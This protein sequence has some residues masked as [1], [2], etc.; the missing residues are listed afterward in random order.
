VTEAWL[1]DELSRR[2][3]TTPEVCYAVKG[4]DGKLYLDLYEDRIKQPIDLE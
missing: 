2:R 4:T 1:M 3:L